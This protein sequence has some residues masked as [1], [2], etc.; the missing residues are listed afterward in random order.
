MEP[1]NLVEVPIDLGFVFT[2]PNCGLNCGDFGEQRRPDEDEDPC[3][4]IY[5]SPSRVI[6]GNCLGVFAAI[7]V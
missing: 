4:M 7:P 5:R 6:C 1:E 2:C 3:D